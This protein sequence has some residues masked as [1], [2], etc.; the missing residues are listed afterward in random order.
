[1]WQGYHVVHTKAYQG[2]NEAYTNSSESEYH[3]RRAC[4]H[5][6]TLVIVV[7]VEGNAALPH[8]NA[9]ATL[10]ND[11][12]RGPQM[13]SGDK[14]CQQWIQDMAGIHA[15]TQLPTSLRVCSR[16]M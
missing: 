9:E 16:E 12:M 14:G 15:L 7:W 2:D 4:Q 11:F 5:P 8:L 10:L 3:H 13:N 1:M 6:L